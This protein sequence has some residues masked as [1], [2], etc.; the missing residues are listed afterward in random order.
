M[1]R[2]VHEVGATAVTTHL[3][4]QIRG[5]KCWNRIQK[6]KDLQRCS[7]FLHGSVELASPPPVEETSEETKS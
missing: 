7:R 1:A 6:L 5:L 2:A 4:L 3:L